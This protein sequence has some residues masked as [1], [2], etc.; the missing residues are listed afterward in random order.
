MA[1]LKIPKPFLGYD[2][3]ISGKATLAAEDVRFARTIQRIQKIVVSEM[4]KIAMLHLYVQ[5]YTDASLVNFKL[6]LLID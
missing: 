1:A 5:G 6:N 4:T 3:G 2:E